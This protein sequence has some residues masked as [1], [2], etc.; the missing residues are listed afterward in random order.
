MGRGFGYTSSGI[1]SSVDRYSQYAALSLENAVRASNASQETMKRNFQK[2]APEASA[3][4]FV[5]IE[6]EDDDD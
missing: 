2:Y 4:Y 6:I 5:E 1:F 3:A